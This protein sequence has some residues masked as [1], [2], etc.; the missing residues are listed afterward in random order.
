MCKLKQSELLIQITKLRDNMIKTGLEKGLDNQETIMIS[1]DLDH[2][3]NR[4]Q[5]EKIS[6]NIPVFLFCKFCEVCLVI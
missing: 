1:K 3:L 4:Y 6:K 5:L 2:L